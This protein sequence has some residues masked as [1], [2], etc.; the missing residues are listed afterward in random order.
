MTKYEVYFVGEREMEG[1]FEGKIDFENQTFIYKDSGKIVIVPLS[2]IKKLVRLE[3][4]PR[5]PMQESKGY[6]SQL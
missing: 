2:S 4:K 3:D 6:I 1:E 5:E